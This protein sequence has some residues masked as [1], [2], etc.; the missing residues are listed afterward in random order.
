M[1][2]FTVQILLS[3]FKLA[4]LS[5]L[6][7]ILTFTVT[8]KLIE[9]ELRFSRLVKAIRFTILNYALFYQITCS[10]IN[11]CP[12]FLKLNISIF[13]QSIVIQIINN[14]KMFIYLN[15]LKCRT[16]QLWL[17]TEHKFYINPWQTIISHQTFKKKSEVNFT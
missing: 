11:H 8:V 5:D 16:S 12:F 17:F 7:I 4:L 9:F 15:A 3:I 1:L 10:S 13:N 2:Y 6:N 14:P